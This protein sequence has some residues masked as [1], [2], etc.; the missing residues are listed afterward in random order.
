M[1]FILISYYLKKEFG[2]NWVKVFYHYS[3]SGDYFINLNETLN[4]SSTNKYSI[5]SFI[6]NKFKINNKFEFLLEYPELN[7]YNR[8]RQSLHPLENPDISG[9]VNGYEEISIK[10]NGGWVGLVKSYH[11]SYTL[12][13]GWGGVDGWWYSIG[14]LVKHVT[15]NTIPGP[16][17]FEIN[18]C[19]L[20][21]RIDNL[22]LLNLKTN[23]FKL[24]FKFFS[25]L[26]YNFIII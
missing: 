1:I 22:N 5:L 15:P 16:Y 17:K 14:S 7:G 6:D 3:G 12:L 25:L 24:H 23:N 18:N 10:W 9:F 8:W 2:V 4:C 13:D 21:L 26:F 19:S 11:T 20:W